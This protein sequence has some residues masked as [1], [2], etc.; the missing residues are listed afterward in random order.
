MMLLNFSHNLIQSV[1]HVNSIFEVSEIKKNLCNRESEKQ[2]FTLSKKFLDKRG[3]IRV[4]SAKNDVSD[5]PPGVGRC[6]MKQGGGIYGN[7]RYSTDGW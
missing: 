3:V 4:K 1:F 6:T 7:T 2:F 5:I